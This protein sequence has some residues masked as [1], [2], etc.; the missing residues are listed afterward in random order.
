[1]FVADLKDKFNPVFIERRRK[2]LERFLRRLLDHPNLENNETM[3]AFLS[4]QNVKRLV[5]Q[6]ILI[7]G[8]FAWLIQVPARY[9]QHHMQQPQDSTRLWIILVI[10]W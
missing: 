8:R 10:F 2:S 6:H 9:L 1:M 7:L 4:E 3:R 5:F